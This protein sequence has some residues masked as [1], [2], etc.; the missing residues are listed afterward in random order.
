MTAEDTDRRIRRLERGRPRHLAPPEDLERYR[1]LLP[2]VKAAWP[3]LEPGREFK[4]GPLVEAI[5][6]HLEAVTSGCIK[7]LLINV[8][9][10]C[11]KS[12]GSCRLAGW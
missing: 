10:G 9:P 2:F 3:V 5:A 11:A 12:L 4:C 1:R 6:E 7:K 8:P